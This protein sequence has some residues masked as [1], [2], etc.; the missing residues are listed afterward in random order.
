MS[1]A[2]LLLINYGGNIVLRTDNIHF[3]LI[4]FSSWV[5]IL[6]DQALARGRK[7]GNELVRDYPA[8]PSC[9][10]SVANETA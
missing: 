10:E 7:L 9:L 1:L 5:H 2:L 4:N 8:T 3:H 6:V